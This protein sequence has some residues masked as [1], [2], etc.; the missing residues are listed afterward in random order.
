MIG[1]KNQSM[2]RLAGWWGNKEE[3]RFLMNRNFEPASDATGWQL[4]TP[5]ILLFA[6]LK[7]SLSIFEHAGWNNILAKQDLMKRWLKFLLD[8]L[9]DADPSGA[10]KCLTPASRGCQVSLYFAENGKKIFEK[11]TSKGFMVDWR[12]P[13]VIRLAPVP[14]YN[15]FTEIWDFYEALRTILS[16]IKSN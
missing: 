10:I 15:S 8:D 11:I 6:C 13:G 1:Y 16:E 12:E 4:S 14:L 2:N 5:S 9:I 3:N 7:A